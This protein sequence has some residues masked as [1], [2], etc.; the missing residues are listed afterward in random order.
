VLATFVVMPNRWVNRYGWR[1]TTPEEDV[2]GV[3]YYRR[4]GALMGIWDLPEDPAGFERPLDA[5]ESERFAFDP[6]SRAVADAIL[7]PVTSFYPRPPA[8]VVRRV[9]IASMDPTCARPSAACSRIDAC[10]VGIETIAESPGGS[11]SAVRACSARPPPTASASPGSSDAIHDRL[12]AAPTT[13]NHAGEMPN[14]RA[15]SASRSGSPEVVSHG[16]PPA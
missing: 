2:A 11:P 1:S 12:A 9:S 3:A 8:P 14:R 15:S 7:A 5:Y 10:S 16:R 6:K 13:G 4:L